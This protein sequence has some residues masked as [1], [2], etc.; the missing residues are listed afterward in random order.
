M[1]HPIFRRLPVTAS[2]PFVVG[3]PRRVIAPRKAGSVGAMPARD[4]HA[5]GHG[6]DLAPSVRQGFRPCT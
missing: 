4:A 6:N 1:P 3:A 5:G 2:P